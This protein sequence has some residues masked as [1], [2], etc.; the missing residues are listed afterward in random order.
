MVDEPPSKTSFTSGLQRLIRGVGLILV[1]FL[2]LMGMGQLATM[3]FG[4]RSVSA[5]VSQL[6]ADYRPWT[7]EQVFAAVDNKLLEE[8]RRDGDFSGEVVEGASFWLDPDTAEISLPAPEILP[9]ATA[10]VVFTETPLPTDTLLATLTASALPSNTLGPSATA[11]LS[12]TPS[13][14]GTP[15]PTRTTSHTPTATRTR[16]STSTRTPT[17]TRTP[18][19]AATILPTATRT[20][21]PTNA[22]A[23]ATPTRTNTPL[24]TST[25]SLTPTPSSSATVTASVTPT[26]T[27]TPSVT[28]TPSSTLTGTPPPSSTLTSTPTETSTLTHTASPSRTATPTLTPTLTETPTPTLTPPIIL[29]VNVIGDAPDANTADGLCE[30][31][32]AGECS[33]RAAIE[34]ANAT[35]G[36][37]SIHFNIPGPGPHL[38]ALT[39]ALPLITEAV[40]IDGASEPD[41]VSNANQPIVIIDGND[42]AAD[43]LRLTATADGSSIRGLVI[44]DFAGN[45]I[46]INSDSNGHNLTGNYI[47]ALN[48]L[49]QFVAGEQ[50]ASAAIRVDGSN[51]T[52]GGV[53]MGLGNVLAGNNYSGLSFPFGSANNVVIGNYIGVAADGTTAVPGTSFGVIAW[54]GATQIRIGGAAAGEGNIIAN[55]QVGVLVDDFPTNTMNISILGNSIYNHSQIG[56]D[57]DND[58]VTVNDA[59]DSDGGPNGLQNYPVLISASTNGSQFV[60]HGALTSTASALFRLEFFANAAASPNGFGEGARYLGAYTAA[61]NTDGVLHFSALLPVT[62][63]PWE[64]VS[65]TATDPNGNTS[66]FSAAIAPALTFVVNT[67]TD[68]PDANTADGLCETFT[69]GECTLRAAIEQANATTGFNA[70]WFNLPGAGPH[71]LAIS[72]AL[73]VMTDVVAIDGRTEPD[74]AG[75]PVIELNGASAGAGA[76]GLQLYSGASGSTVHGLAINGFSGGSAIRLIDSANNLIAANYLGTDVTGSAAHANQTGVFI[77]GA[78]AVRNLVGGPTP[79]DRNIISGNNVDGIQILSSASHNL[80]IGNYIGLDVTGAAVISNTNQ[81]IAIFGGAFS[82]LVGGPLAVERNLISGNGGEG[83]RLAGIGTDNNLIQGN[84]IGTDVTGLLD[85]GNGVDGIFVTNDAAYNIIGGATA[86]A[87][88]LIAGNTD[89]GVQFRHGSSHNR[90]EGNWI[91]VAADGLTLLGN[92]DDGIRVQDDATLSVNNALLG[93]WIA[94]SGN[95]GIDIGADGVTPND[96]DDSDAG[97]NNLQNFPELSAATTT[98]SQLTVTGTLTSTAG[99]TF[100]IEFFANAIP[101]ISGH[102]EGQRY[103]GAYIAATDVNGIL[104]FSVMLTATV[105]ATETVTATATDANGNTSE[106]GPNVVVLSA[107]GLNRMNRTEARLVL[108]KNEPQ[109][110]LRYRNQNVS[111]GNTACNRLSHTNKPSGHLA[112]STWSSA[113]SRA[114]SGVSARRGKKVRSRAMAARWFTSVA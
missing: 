56:I 51:T 72:S 74:Y 65:A 8:A 46:R 67:V 69:P 83:I 41:F 45:G 107:G 48:T 108:P 33:L 12:H 106:F 15:T 4:P 36:A 102:G 34:Q 2:L 110:A 112:R 20:R 87:G 53:G 14:T 49:G 10:E 93:N 11:I 52:I 63:S 114:A 31:A 44:R 105:A 9:S 99:M 79:A 64:W 25:A 7:D 38:I 60:V 39:S 54:N 89:D 100:R 70:I 40:L 98:G 90:V 22:P 62:V 103:L 97:S 24:P 86:G 21:T 95:Q 58:S 66:E 73:P 71:T 84:Y 59:D 55:A 76:S 28:F 88:N 19:S 80:V 23:T 78:G 96:A 82:N 50:N 30:T 92:G 43:G 81:G 113:F 91:G 16:T 32:V 68:A 5:I 3:R 27:S 104:N 42:L 47:G 57:L 13:I 1:I 35:V 17:F 37:N 61:T 6:R 77:F 109:A 18:T 85:V 94:A 111:L 29:V 26:Y 75:A 101:E